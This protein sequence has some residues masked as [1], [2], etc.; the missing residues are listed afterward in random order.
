M[1]FLWIRRSAVDLARVSE[2]CRLSGKCLSNVSVNFAKKE[3]F[4]CGYLFNGL[5]KSAVVFG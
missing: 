1:V 4:K 2:K 3:E 5:T